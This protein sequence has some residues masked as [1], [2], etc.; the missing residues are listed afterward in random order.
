VFQEN[1]GIF[2][3]ALQARF[4]DADL[5]ATLGA[6]SYLGV[7]I[8]DSQGRAISNLGIIDTK[9]LPDN[10]NTI[11]SIL[12]LFAA[13]V[14]AEMEHNTASM[15]DISDRK[16]AEKKLRQNEQK[17]HQILDA[18]TE[19]VLV[20]GPQS[21]IV[22]TNKAFR[23]YYAMT[24]EQLQ[25]MIDA[26]FNEPDY[27]LQYI[28]DDAY[29][30]ETGQSM[31]IEEPVT[32]YDG[33]VHIFNTIKSLIRN[34]SGDKILTVGLSRNISDRKTAEAALSE[35]ADR[36]ILLNQLVNQIRNSLD[37]DAVISTT[38]QSIR[39]LLD[40]DACAFAWYSPNADIPTWEV[41]KEA[42]LEDIPSSL[43][44]YP[45]TFVGPV[46]QLLL[47]QVILRVDDVEQYEEPIHRE[48]LKT[49]NCQSEI[50]N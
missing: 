4:P 39:N 33:K 49:I 48:F 40:I 7:V 9:P 19:M 8:I 11:K 16:A 29:V 1:W 26:P 15:F 38:I 47:K 13:R 50:Q 17:Y 37:L 10:L 45:S 5:L 27:T 31:E 18:I 22:W 32:R 44:C 21:R 36:Q 34:E 30:F 25:D 35:Y 6:Q 42:K 23:D 2:P 24:N 28:K 41:I 14:G 46:D 12:Q 20:K 3:D 43:G